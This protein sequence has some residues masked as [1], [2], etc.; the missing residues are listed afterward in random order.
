MN[1]YYKILDKLKKENERL[2]LKNRKLKRKKKK[3]S[4]YIYDLLTGKKGTY[5]E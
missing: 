1:D 3:L 4:K 5:L 2:Y